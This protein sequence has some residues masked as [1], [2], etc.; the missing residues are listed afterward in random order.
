M[1][2]F[3]AIEIRVLPDGD[4]SQDV[5]VAIRDYRLGFSELRR[6]ESLSDTN[7]VTFLR[8]IDCVTSTPRRDL[9]DS[10]RGATDGR[11]HAARPLFILARRFIL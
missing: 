4:V 11:R 7:P 10:R 8:L 9:T 1:V 6:S 5:T 3:S 2:G